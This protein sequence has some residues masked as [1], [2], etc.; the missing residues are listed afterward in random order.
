MSKKSILITGG[1]G[2]LGKNLANKLKH[3]YP[4]IKNLC[5]SNTGPEIKDIKRF[6]QES[7]I[8]YLKLDYILG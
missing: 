6:C 4:A 8:R 2:Y 3:K 7:E 5:F 1:T